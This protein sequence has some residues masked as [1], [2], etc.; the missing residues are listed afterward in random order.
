VIRRLATRTSKTEG[1][2]ARKMVT[3]VECLPH[4]WEGCL[5]SIPST[6]EKQPVGMALLVISALRRHSPENP[7]KLNSQ[8]SQKEEL[9][10]TTRKLVSK[11]KVESSQG[12]TADV[13]LWLPYT[14]AH[15][16]AHTKYLRGK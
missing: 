9:W 3:S 12:A 14:G 7:C 2:G 1:F 11:T 10:V 5:S 6:N 13:N 8:P 15:P 4:K 16:H